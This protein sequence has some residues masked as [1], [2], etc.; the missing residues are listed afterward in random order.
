MRTFE[1]GEDEF[2]RALEIV[3]KRGISDMKLVGDV[4]Q[5]HSGVAFSVDE[6]RGDAQDRFAFQAMLF[7]ACP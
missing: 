4:R 5:R 1:A 2:F 6:A 7:T 3:V